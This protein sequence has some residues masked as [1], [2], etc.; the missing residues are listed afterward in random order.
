MLI[1][2]S[3]PSPRRARLTLPVYL[4]AVGVLGVALLAG[5]VAAT[6][7][8]AVDITLTH[9]VLA[10]F[11]VFGELL[12]IRVPGHDDEVNT[13]G[14]FSFALLVLVGLA[15][16]AVAQ[17][18]ASA[19]ADLRLGKSPGSVMFNVGQYTI[20][21]AAAGVMLTFAAGGVH[22]LG[23]LGH[24]N[25]PALFAAGVTFFAV[26][27]VLAGAA[28][29]IYMRA[30]ILSHLR[31]DLSFQAWTA[32][33]VLGFAPI[34]IAMARYDAY[35]LPFLL[36]PLLAIYRAGRHARLSEHQALHDRLTELPN[37]VFFRRSAEE[38][39][40]S[41]GRDGRTVS[42]LIMDLNRFKEINDTLGHLHGDLLLQQVAARL[43]ETVRAGDTVARLGGDEFAVLL[44]RVD[45]IE[46]AEG[47]ARRLLAALKAPVVI[48]GVSLT[49]EASIG[50]ACFPDHGDGVDLLLQ[51]ADVAMYVA[52][53]AHAGVQVYSQA[54]DDHSIERLSLAAELRRAIADG[55]MVLHFQPQLDLATGRLVAAEGLMRWA[56]PTR[57]LI[58]PSTFISIAEN[59]GA[60]RQLTSRALELAVAECARW[61][62]VGLDIGV[63]VNVSAQD[64]LDE[65]LP[66]EIRALLTRCGVP[67][68][69]LEL[70]LTESMLMADPQRAQAVLEALSAMGVRTAIDDFGTGYSSLAYLKRLPIDHIK[71]D[72]SFVMNM[73]QDRNDAL[74]VESTVD[75]ARNLG[76]RTVAEGIENEE[77][78][79]RLAAMG[80][81]VGQ[82]F[83][84]AAPMAP[85]AFLAWA[86]AAPAGS[87]AA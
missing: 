4:T 35:M 18:L 37:R 20:S 47:L 64:V 40:G 27:N 11:L 79:A 80:C 70:E 62:A 16:A 8:G 17:A 48:N 78:R 44:P 60:I 15:P 22:P 77:A 7:W 84:F 1:S 10:L 57:G 49:V 46:A 38:A 5:L 61:H 43:Q 26:N 14:S 3:S 41:A 53:S 33:L 56:H 63:S 9:V 36:L 31:S 71:I 29:A 68:D 59:T 58:P 54:Q 32:A 73:H 69:A 86:T 81:D 19:A 13:S 39:I 42:V 65:D 25:L 52:K 34:V 6:D 55:Q 45:G 24:E 76:L 50:V 67:A 83:H 12:P 28:Y 30:P 74:I 85:S 2:G 23:A 82:G 66:T 75:L 87:L 72:R 21:L 51:R